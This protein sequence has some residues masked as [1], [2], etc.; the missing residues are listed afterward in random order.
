MISSSKHLST[1]H[2]E[3]LKLSFLNLLPWNHKLLASYQLVVLMTSSYWPSL[4]ATRVIISACK[5]YFWTSSL[6]YLCLNLGSI[7][8]ISLSSAVLRNVSKFC[9]QNLEGL[10]T[11]SCNNPDLKYLGVSMCPL[12]KIPQGKCMRMLQY[13]FPQTCQIASK[14]DSGTLMSSINIKKSLFFMLSHDWIIVTLK[15]TL[16]FH[17]LPRHFA[18]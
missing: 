5:A 16:P 17:D 9:K 14:K 13:I 10:L 11:I 3:L 12:N 15:T 18:T 6:I 8:D 4:L 7:R 1:F 2:T